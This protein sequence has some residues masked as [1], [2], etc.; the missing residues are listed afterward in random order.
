MPKIIKALL[1]CG[2]YDPLKMLPRLTNAC[3]ATDPYSYV[4]NTDGLLYKCT[5]DNMNP[6]RSVG[7]VRDGVIMNNLIIDWTS[8]VLPQKCHECKM[9]P[10]CQGGCRAN[11]ILNMDATDCE[12]KKQLI[13]ITL[14][15]LLNTVT[16]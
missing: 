14:N 16:L 5:M 4:I 3:F 2:Y 10:I 12:M 7:N 15:H 9:L 11:R 8:P 6:S 13:E 1:E